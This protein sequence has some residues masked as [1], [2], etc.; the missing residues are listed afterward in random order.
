MILP[1]QDVGKRR[2]H[3]MRAVLHDGRP[4]DVQL[5]EGVGESGEENELA[6]HALDG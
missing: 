3:H 5:A 6:D 2:P 4:N 1:P